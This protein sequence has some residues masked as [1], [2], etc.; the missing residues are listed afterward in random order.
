MKRFLFYI[1]Y[2]ILFYFNFLETPTSTTRSPID[3]EARPIFEVLIAFWAREQK[4]DLPVPDELLLTAVPY[5]LNS[6]PVREIYT[7]SDEEEEEEM[8]PTY[9]KSF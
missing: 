1:L 5:F 6:C 7:Q 4:S 8:G 2:F 3:P 9:I